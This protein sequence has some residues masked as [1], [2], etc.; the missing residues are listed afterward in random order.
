MKKRILALVMSLS[1]VFSAFPASMI[2]ASGGANEETAIAQAARS[3]VE[4][5]GSNVAEDA[6][7]FADYTN[8][9]ASLDNLNN[10][11]FATDSGYSS[12]NTWNGNGDLEYP[13]KVGYNW[14]KEYTLSGMRVMWW[15][16]NANLTSSD[17][18]T[19]PKSCTVEYLNEEG[20]WVAITGM[21]NEEGLE[22]DQVGVKYDASDGNGINGKNQYWNEVTFPEEITTTGLRMTVD[23]NGSSRNGVGISEWE[24]FGYR[25]PD[26]I[27]TGDNIAATAA[28]EADYTNAESQTASINNGELATSD[29]ASTWNTWKEEGDLSYPTPVTLTWEKEQ[30]I[31]SL[32]VMWWADNEKVKFPESCKVSYYDEKAKD[33][34]EITDMFDESGA[35]VSSVGVLHDGENDGANENN[36]Y[37]NGVAF[38]EPV[39]TTQ[40]RL[41]VNRSQDETG[42]SGIGIGELQVFGKEV[43]HVIGEGENIAPDASSVVAAHENTPAS[44]VNDGALAT[45][46]AGTSWNTWNNSQGYP[47]PITLVWDDPYEISSMQVMWWADNPV[48]NYPGNVT[49][50]K[51]CMVEYLTQDGEWV[52]IDAMTNEEG[53]KVSSVGVKYNGNNGGINGNNNYWN[54]VMFDE[55][56]R[57]TQLRLI[58]DRNGTSSNGVGISEWEV[59][60]EPV[61]DE[62]FGARITGSDRME[63]G[64]SATYQ[65]ESV[66][67]ALAEAVSYEWS[68][69]EEYQ[70]ILQL[71]GDPTSSSITVNGISRGEGAI[72]LKVTYG[73]DVKTESFDIRVEE[74]ESIDAY[75]TSTAAG[76]A[77]ILPKTVVA[78]GITFDDPTPDLF[79]WTNPEFNFAETFDSKLVPVT[80]EDVDP[81]LYAEDQVGSTFTVNGTVEFGGKQYDAKAEITVREPVVAPEANSSVTFENVHLTD[82]FWQPKQKINAVNSLNAAIYQIGQASGG[83]PNFDNAIKKLNGEPYD[84]FQGYVFQDSDIYKSIEA[85]SYTLSVI[86]DDTDPEMVEQRENLEATLARWISKIE[87]VQY[88]DGYINTHFTLRSAAHSGGSS[89][90]THRWRDFSNHEMYNA[91]HFFEGVVAYTRYREGIGDPDYSLYVVGKRFADEIVSLFGPNGTRHE[92]PG[93]EEIELALVK[94]AKLVEEYEG[95]GT[96]QKYIDTAKLLIDRRG[97]DSTLRESGYNGGDYSQ[98]ARPFVEETNGVGHAVRAN[99]FY[100]GVTD[101]ATLLPDGDPDKEAYLNT[102]DHI[103][104]SVANRKTYITGGIGVASHGEDFGNDYE[105]PNNGS[106][107]ETCA[108]IALANWNQRMNLVHEDA[109]YADVVERNLYNAILVGT[110]LEGNLFYYSTLLEVSNGNRR[111]SWFGCACCPPNL[112]RT[113]AKLSEY[114]YSVHGDDVFVNMYVGSEGSINV[115]GTKVALKQETNYPWEGSIKMTVSPE[116]QKEF[117]MKIRIPGWVQEQKN[118]NVSITVNGEAVTAAA[119]KGYVSITREWSE[120]DVIMIDIPMEIR[121]T[122]ADP[123]VV[124]NAGRIALQRGPI[125]YCMEKAGNAQLN[126]EISNF[127][128]LNF[129][130]PRDA[131]LTATYNPDLLKGVVEITG[132]VTYDTGNGLVPAKLQAV[133]YYAWNNRGDDGVYG[134]NSS[135]KM[136]IWTK[137]SGEIEDDVYGLDA[138]ITFMEGLNEEEYTPESWAVLQEALDEAKAL[139][140][141]NA[142]TQ[143]QIDAAIAKLVAAF[144]NLEYGVQ[145]QHLQ[146]AVDAADAILAMEANYDAESIAALKEVVEQAKSVLADSAATQ[147][148]V[149]E[150]TSDLIDAI[151]RVTLD[152]DVV[153]LERLIEAI[154]SLNPDKYTSD[155]WAALEEAIEAAKEVL[156]NAD[157]DENDLAEAYV[158]I[159]QALRKLEMKG[160]K[161]ALGAVIEKAEKILADASRYTESS[162][163]GLS[164]ALESA[165]L[166]NENADATQAEVDQAVEAL[167]SVVVLAR[168]KGD[169]DNDGT[170][171]TDDSTALLR[172][173]AELDGLDARAVE[174]ADVNGDGA[175]DTKDAVLILQYTAEKISEF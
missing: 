152:E 62:L 157:R 86:H 31:S 38:K 112:M 120:G 2:Y 104:D 15:A 58:I 135:S 174:G 77:P 19:F 84:S 8:I 162:I 65:G 16:D 68:V 83:E 60:G 155:S 51:S 137:A 165:K 134:Q 61:T 75:A 81:A 97:E 41:E 108:A 70:D 67:S 90:G 82:T 92:V 79:S 18:V 96:G 71:E 115:R 116:T 85:I 101:I 151:V 107:C 57:T 47:T 9:Y 55:P 46:N 37:W 142:A 125:V 73:E 74:I 171:T 99:Y 130:I 91:G 98:D 164:D 89:P 40:L 111:S 78:N 161:A 33:W 175:A 87:Q 22:T 63:V 138:W 45:S 35:A 23:R 153:S 173:N 123:N 154:E 169:V 168:L 53:E 72:N 32:Q 150:I 128:P 42:A 132:E 140:A 166:V 27:G 163:S 110:N 30:E 117:T 49:F 39:R 6:A 26:P 56:I 88:A 13:V 14:D 59:F 102:L 126:E 121:K 44:N 69:P 136:L 80:W 103:W 93:H 106:Y 124:T 1:M 11:E 43:V 127:N 28:V 113:I 143:A 48:L 54:G 158:Q 34:V 172:Y 4:D 100:A 146:V 170:I 122:E 139:N 149:N 94:F 119:E 160:N 17:N 10:G 147:D 156:A 159:S 109:K 167:T 52:R 3:G 21:V 50:P 105:L 25:V 131:Q 76:K 145:K 144:G 66:P 118:K 36:R 20:E 141:D 133:P 114:M 12:W 7:P 129:V 64:G 5:L 24:V 29:P 148:T 95:E